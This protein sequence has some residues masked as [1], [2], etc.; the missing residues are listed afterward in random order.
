MS[1]SAKEVAPKAASTE[2]PVGE[3]KDIVAGSGGD[4][5]PSS[6]TES[7]SVADSGNPTEK[8]SEA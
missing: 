1:S 5:A 3:K 7:G 2:M 6:A 8:G 4:V